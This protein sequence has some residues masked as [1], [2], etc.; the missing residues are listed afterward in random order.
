MYVSINLEQNKKENILLLFYWVQK[1]K[2]PDS[3]K[4]F[5]FVVMPVDVLMIFGKSSQSP[6]FQ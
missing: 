6:K 5:V 4:V 1:V 3:S 2:A